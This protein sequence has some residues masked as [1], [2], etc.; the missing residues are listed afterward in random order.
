[1]ERKIIIEITQ[2]KK[3]NFIRCGGFEINPKSEAKKC[4][5]KQK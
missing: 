4:R 3:G 2:N 5:I 1:M